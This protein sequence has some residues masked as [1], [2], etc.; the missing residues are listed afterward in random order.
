MSTSSAHSD[1]S[2]TRAS[3]ARAQYARYDHWGESDTDN[4]TEKQDLVGHDPNGNAVTQQKIESLAHLW[5]KQTSQEPFLDPVALCE[6]TENGQHSSEGIRADLTD[7][8]VYPPTANSQVTARSQM[9]KKAPSSKRWR[10]SEEYGHLTYGGIIRD[11]PKDKLLELV[12]YVSA[13]IWAV[14][15]PPRNQRDIEEGAQKLKQRGKLHDVQ[16]MRRVAEWIFLPNILREDKKR[17]FRR[18]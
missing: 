15:V 2:A 12:G 13:N 6:P 17:D 8:E 7:P 9:E 16:I 5:L 1:E 4:E 18:K 11:R 14:D 3:H 10:Y